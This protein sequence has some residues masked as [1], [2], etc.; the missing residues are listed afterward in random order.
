MPKSYNLVLNSLNYLSTA[1]VNTASSIVYNVDW[2]FLPEG[3]DF[4][5]SFSFHSLDGN[6]DASSLVQLY[7]YFGG[8]STTYTANGTNGY[9]QTAMIGT[10]HSQSVTAT[11]GGNQ[12][13]L[14]TDW[15]NNPPFYLRSRPTT[16]QFG[17][18]LYEN[19]GVLFAPAGG[20]PNYIM[21]L[22]FEEL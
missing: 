21:T 11:G 22:H 6:I 15:T 9:Q 1:N 20:M 7:V 14:Q 8:Q 19:D 5:C 17:V 12:N 10:L 4:Q 2:G 18:Q 3:K 13:I 16:N